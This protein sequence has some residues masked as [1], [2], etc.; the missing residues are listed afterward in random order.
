[1][2]LKSI[3]SLIDEDLKEPAKKR[4]FEEAQKR[5]NAAVEIYDLR[6]QMRLS[7]R[8]LAKK[9][10]VSKKVIIQIEQG[11]M[12]PSDESMEIMEQVLRSLGKNSNSPLAYQKWELFSKN[13]LTQFY[14]SSTLI[15]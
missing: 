8:Q 1:M 12:I 9:S 14:C 3:D 15:S 2:E 11:Q 5:N 6:N 13:L 4:L 7:R 10:G